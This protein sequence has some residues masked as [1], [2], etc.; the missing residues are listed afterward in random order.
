MASVASKSTFCRLRVLLDVGGC[1]LSSHGRYLVVVV[2]SSSCWSRAYSCSH[3]FNLELIA[4][5]PSFVSQPNLGGSCEEL[6]LAAS[7]KA[8]PTLSGVNNGCGSFR[9]SPRW[10]RYHGHQ[11]HLAPPGENLVCSFVGR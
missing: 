8:I 7:A 9:H 5:S 3:S 1:R 4:A 2:A 10:G 11:T 6:D